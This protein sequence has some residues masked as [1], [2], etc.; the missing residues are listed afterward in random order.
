MQRKR[1]KIKCYV[2]KIAKILKQVKNK[3]KKR[4]IYEGETIVD[5]EGMKMRKYTIL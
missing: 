1:E 4:K 3:Q 2:R 5:K